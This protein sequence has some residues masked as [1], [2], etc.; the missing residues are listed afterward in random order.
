MISN[1]LNLVEQQRQSAEAISAQVAQYLAAGGRID[2]LKSP[3]RNPLPPPRS[4]RI[5]P[6]TV[7]KRRPKPISA[8]DRKTLRKMA[9]SI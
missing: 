6:E 9:D 8:A 3:P 2:K 5:D 4:T 1:H 7:L